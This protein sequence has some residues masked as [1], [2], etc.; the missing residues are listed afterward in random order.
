MYFHSVHGKNIQLSADSSEARRTSGFCQGITFSNNPMTQFE[1]VT[2]LVG[3]QQQ[4]EKQQS[5]SSSSPSHHQFSHFNQNAN[6][7]L[8]LNNN[9]FKHFFKRSNKK[10]FWTGNLRIGLTT[11]NPVTLTST[12][13][14]NFSYPSLV[15]TE[16]FWIA[17]IKSS[18]LRAGNKISLVLDKNNS[19]QL[20]VNYVV[21]ATLFGNS[22]VP[23]TPTLKL[24]LILDL[25]GNT[26][27]V[28]FLPSGID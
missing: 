9:G 28:K 10:S 13:L 4:P 1:R 23:T 3:Q 21:N 14:P 18:Y 20:S 15:N 19:L 24:W 12:D 27:I 2:F 16:C 11:K 22:M 17:V 6:H 7:H 8:L 5:F 25:Y 26:N